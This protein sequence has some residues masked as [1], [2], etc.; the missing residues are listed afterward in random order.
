MFYPGLEHKNPWVREDSL[1]YIVYALLLFPSSDF[2]LHRLP[3]AVAPMLA[4]PKRRCRQA[5]LEAAAVLAQQLGARRSNL[6][7]DAVGE[8]RV[9]RSEKH[10]DLEAAV[11][12]RTSRRQLPRVTD[13]GYV[14][15]GLQVPTD[16][17]AMK[18][19]RHKQAVDVGA[20]VEW[21]LKAGG[22]VSRGTPNF[23][24]PAPSSAAAANGNLSRHQSWGSDRNVRNGSG[25]DSD[26]GARR[27]R[28]YSRSHSLTDGIKDEPWLFAP[29][30]ADASSSGSDLN[31]A[32]RLPGI[33]KS[34][35]S[36]RYDRRSFA[37]INQNTLVI[38]R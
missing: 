26:D 31:R 18:N 7:Q 32:R 24:N 6:L 13:D 23:F 4:D 25:G 1:L 28:R 35:Y 27:G 37:S 36:H 3:K 19:G 34:D 10:S 8:V 29:P 14:E 17:Y 15:Y 9:G 5:A 12:M 20:D 16:Y 30:S 38:T 22:V 2:D 33:K 21:I 11:H